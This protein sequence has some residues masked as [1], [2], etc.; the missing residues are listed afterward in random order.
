MRNGRFHCEEGTRRKSAGDP[1]IFTSSSLAHGRPPNF[2]PTNVDGGWKVIRNLHQRDPPKPPH[3]LSLPGELLKSRTC[4]IKTGVSRCSSTSSPPAITFP[5]VQYFISITT[6]ARLRSYTQ[7]TNKL[8]MCG[9]EGGHWAVAVTCL[10]LPFARHP[11]PL[12]W[13]FLACNCLFAPRQ[14]LRGGV[15]FGHPQ[16]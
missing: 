4:S 11:F 9:R 6:K 16:R 2:C 12:P 5:P 8:E 15:G 14:S 1:L 13:R 10:P 3:P 7:F